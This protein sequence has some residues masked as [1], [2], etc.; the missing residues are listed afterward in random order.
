MTPTRSASAAAS[1]KS[2]VTSRVGRSELAEELLQLD[3]DCRARVC[4]ERGQRLVEQEHPRAACERPGEPDPLALSARELGRPGLGK[5]SDPEAVEKLRAPRLPAVDD[6]LLDRHVREERVL[7]EDETDA[8]TLGRHVDAAPRSRTARRPASS[9]RPRSGG[10]G[11]RSRA[12]LSTSRRPKA[13]PAR[14]SRGR[15]RALARAGTSEGERRC[16]AERVHRG[17]SL[18]V[19]RMAAL[20]STSSALIAS[21]TS[22]STSN[23]A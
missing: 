23:C 15:S 17:R 12:G 21:A 4:V 18:T 3:A 22:K 20:R 19:S 2:C 13:R 1:S 11:R 7:L 9:I 6:V 10:R 16:R 8:A 5:V 14:P